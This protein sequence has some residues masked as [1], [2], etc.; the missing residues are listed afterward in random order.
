MCYKLSTFYIIYDLKKSISNSS[1]TK[2]VNGVIHYGLGDFYNL[3]SMDYK[4]L[5]I[6]LTLLTS[7]SL[8]LILQ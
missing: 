7:S 3:S 2:G 1:M 6:L 4:Y 5:I 8:V